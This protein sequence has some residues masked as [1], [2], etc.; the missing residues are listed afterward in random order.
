MKHPHGPREGGQK[1]NGGTLNIRFVKPDIHREIRYITRLAQAADSRVVSVGKLV[2]FSTHSRDAWLLDAEDN[3]AICLCRNGDP[4]PFRVVDAPQTF[5]IEWT[6]DFEIDGP[7]FIV[8]E[9][10]GKIIEINGYP[11]AEI[12]A[13]CRALVGE[14]NS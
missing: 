14:E 6:A 13:A 5:A 7:T 2:L 11:T 4:Q 3:F 1:P 9:R 8:Q 12:S 10:S